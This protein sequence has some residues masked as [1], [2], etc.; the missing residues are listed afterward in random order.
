MPLTPTTST[1]LVQAALS[2]AEIAGKGLQDYAVTNNPSLIPQA[3]T[4][5]T[6]L[7]GALAALGYDASSVKTFRQVATRCTYPTQK[8]GGSAYLFAS[9]H[10]VFE[11][12][13]TLRL[14]Y[15]GRYSQ[16]ET[17]Q[18]NG[19]TMSLL[20]EY[21]PFSGNQVPMTFNG[22][23]QKTN[24]Q[25]EDFVTDT[26]TLPFTIKA[27]TKFRIKGGI[28]TPFGA[29][30]TTMGSAPQL[31]TQL[32][33][34][35][36]TGVTA[37]NVFTL[38]DEPTAT[39]NARTNTFGNFTYAILP[40][41]IEGMG[42]IPALAITGDSRSAGGSADFPNDL[43]GL[44]GIAVRLFG[45]AYPVIN[46]SQSGEKGR[47]W[48]NG[49]QGLHRRTFVPKCQGWVCAHGT[50]DVPAE[51][52]AAN[53]ISIDGL[54]KGLITSLLGKAPYPSFS[55]TLPPNTGDSTSRWDSLATQ[56]P[57]TGAAFRSA[58]NAYRL[59]QQG[60]GLLFD[61]VLDAGPLATDAASAPDKW[62]IS[63]G[64]RTLAVTTTAG[65]NVVN[66]TSGTLTLADDGAI[67]KILGSGTAG[68]NVNYCVE[69]VS[70]TQFKL[71]PEGSLG[72][73]N[74]VRLNQNAVTAVTD[75]VAYMGIWYTTNDGIH[76]NQ[77]T[78]IRTQT[79]LQLQYRI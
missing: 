30:I 14:T 77:R 4:K 61:R 65:S 7:A 31:G 41:C 1:D 44:A 29:L 27:G 24:A 79:A 54:L 38:L 16:L 60:T 74:G 22:V 63:P 28:N 19:V 52:S 71:R 34:L 78:G 67:V 76:E 12:Q 9:T 32:D 5:L 13:A 62:Q 73:N 42:S 45:K 17:A 11:D 23:R 49:T 25:G 53:L 58:L 10:M 72:Y 20:I 39:F 36:T 18:D 3:D 43:D 68:A 59:A 69:Y 6:A 35:N 70:P 66:V 48:V 51:T 55:I 26:V 50:N 46:L 56:N 47:A 37:G 40:T 8:L 57:A 33:L 15:S 75:A 64:A 2:R 21:P